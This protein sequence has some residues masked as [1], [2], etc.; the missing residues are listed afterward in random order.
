MCALWCT[1]HSF[2]FNKHKQ[3]RTPLVFH[4]CNYLHSF[5]P[6][7]IIIHIHPSYEWNHSCSPLLWMSITQPCISFVFPHPRMNIITHTYTTRVFS[8]IMNVYNTNKHKYQDTPFNPSHQAWSH[9]SI[10]IINRLLSNI[11]LHFHISHMIDDGTHITLS[12]TT[13]DV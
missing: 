8:A 1:D 6:T 10:I 2:T 7:N 13:L 9:F 3:S 11:K 4:E 12:S 5:S